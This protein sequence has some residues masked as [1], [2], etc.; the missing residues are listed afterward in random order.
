M[1]SVRGQISK[2]PTVKNLDLQEKC[3]LVQ[4][5]FLGRTHFTAGN[6]KIPQNQTFFGYVSVKFKARMSVSSSHQFLMIVY[7]C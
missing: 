3:V 4:N 5:V 7:S 1:N 6:F 2:I